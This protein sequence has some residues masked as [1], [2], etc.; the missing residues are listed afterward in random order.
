MEE[1]LAQDRG[2]VWD[3]M[4]HLCSLTDLQGASGS[5]FCNNLADTRE[6]ADDSGTSSPKMGRSDIE[7]YPEEGEINSEG[8]REREKE[9]C[10]IN[11]NP[12]T[13]LDFYQAN[14]FASCQSDYDLFDEDLFPKTD[15]SGE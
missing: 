8:G 5:S 2:G 7:D 3:G 11:P 13:K 6:E 14:P 1:E 10:I 12:L 9:E 15:T 4:H